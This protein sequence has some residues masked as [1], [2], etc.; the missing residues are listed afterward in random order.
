MRSMQR[1]G[2]CTAV[3]LL[4][5]VTT[6]C[7]I[8]NRA[9]TAG[10]PRPAHPTPVPA[11][12]YT[13]PTEWAGDFTFRWSAADPIDQATPEA[14]FV[15]AFA[16]AK[17]L[18]MAVGS[19][20]SYPGYARAVAPVDWLR[21]PEGGEYPPGATRGDWVLRWAG[22]FHARI[23]RIDTGP[24]SFTAAYC[25]DFDGVAVSGDGGATY[26]WVRTGFG[27]APPT[28]WP[29]WLTA[30]IDPA[31]AQPSSPS[32]ST[33]ARTDRAPNYNAFEGWQVTTAWGPSPRTP[34]EAALAQN[35]TT[36]AR[37]NQRVDVLGTRQD[38]APA[39]PPPA[40][41]PPFPGWPAQDL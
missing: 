18:S 19:D 23:L 36:W 41:E 29:I 8:G 38:G 37:D 21:V 12:D 20:L 32:T 34:D 3:A 31:T 11:A 17:R 5:L 1:T 4:F 16:E 10:P 30:R 7:A 14:V 24:E 39:N 40:P 28:G 25:L 27:G 35:C 13:F 26:R 15:R 9:D 33:T 22:T 2:L 6:A